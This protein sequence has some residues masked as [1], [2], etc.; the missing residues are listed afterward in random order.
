MIFFNSL[1]GLKTPTDLLRL[2]AYLTEKDVSLAK[3]ISL[4]TLKYSKTVAAL[5][6]YNQYRPNFGA[7]VHWFKRANKAQLTL[8][9]NADITIGL[10]DDC[11]INVTQLVAEKI[12]NLGLTNN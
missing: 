9:E 4:K 8:R 10:D 12:F 7:L 3:N 5:V 11:T 6:K 2:F 1:Q